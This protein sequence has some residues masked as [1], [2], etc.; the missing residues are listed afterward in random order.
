MLCF[1]DHG[2][3]EVSL[4]DS[5]CEL[6]GCYF[7][8]RKSFSRVKFVSSSYLGRMG[9]HALLAANLSFRA[10]QQDRHS[11]HVGFVIH[12]RLY[13]QTST[14]MADLSG[15][16]EPSTATSSS[17]ECH[18]YNLLGHY[19]PNPFTRPEDSGSCTALA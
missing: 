14:S 4:P 17:N 11:L 5:V 3:E 9:R 6:C 12:K 8:G 2:V 18:S 1:E 16:P 15:S 13:C 19:L 7:V 10:R